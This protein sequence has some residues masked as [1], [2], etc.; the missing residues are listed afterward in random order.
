MYKFE[1]NP[2]RP[3]RQMCVWLDRV[4]GSR[5]Y[6][7]KGIMNFMIGREDLITPRS[8]TNDGMVKADRFYTGDDITYL[9]LIMNSLCQSMT[10]FAGMLSSKRTCKGVYNNTVMKS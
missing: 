9:T 5:Q 1:Q 3:N 10:A 7:C 4:C 6:W 2:S 8:P